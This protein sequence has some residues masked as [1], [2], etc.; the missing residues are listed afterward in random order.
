MLR[1]EWTQG[2]PLT[3]TGATPGIGRDCFIFDWKEDWTD[4]VRDEDFMPPPGVQCEP[5]RAAAVGV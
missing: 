4:E 1:F 5:R 2:I 3:E